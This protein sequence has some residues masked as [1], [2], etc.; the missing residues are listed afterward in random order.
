MAGKYNGLDRFLERAA[1]AWRGVARDVKLFACAY[2]DAVKGYGERAERRFRREYP[3]FGP[4][5]WRKMELIGSGELLPQ[6]F[7]KSDAFI[8][9]LLRMCESKSIQGD[10]VRMSEKGMLFSDRGDGP[11]P[12]ALSD[13][14]RRED[15]ELARSLDDGRMAAGRR[16]RAMVL[17]VNRQRAPGGRP[18]WNVIRKGGRTMVRIN[19]AC[20][21]DAN[22]VLRIARQMRLHSAEGGNGR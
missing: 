13:M 8:G 7:F 17:H 14:T 18:K 21:L 22:D 12:V 11:R 15:A 6:F 19:R 3:M 2:C 16:V 9:S 5:E 20:T 4:R 1:N 10:I